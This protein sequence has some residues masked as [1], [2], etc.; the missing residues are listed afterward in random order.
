MASTISKL[1]TD[2]DFDNASINQIQLVLFGFQDA[3]NKV[4]RNHVIKP[5]WMFAMDN[6]I[7][8]AVQAA[9][10]ILIP[11]LQTHFEPA[12]ETE[13]DDKEEDEI[14]EDYQQAEQGRPEE[15]VTAGG[16][17]LTSPQSPDTEQKLS[18]QLN[19][20]KQRTNR[21]LE[22]LIQR[23]KEYQTLLQQ[24]LQQKIQDLQLLQL[25]LKTPEIQ[26]LSSALQHN[27]DEEL[28]KWLK[29]QRADSDAIDRVRLNSQDVK[30]CHLLFS[31]HKLFLSVCSRGL[32][33]Q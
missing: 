18:L 33:T 8:R 20:L 29:Q 2:L 7:R 23:E 10:T 16:Y 4:L 24:I 22:N 1:K 19:K 15:S 32:Y 26:P 25:Q 21:L 5:H 6:I 9:I 17:T 28:I 13:V 3:V 31:K 12:S 27:V 11:E 14:E 30:Y